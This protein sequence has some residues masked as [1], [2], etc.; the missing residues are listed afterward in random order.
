MMP[1]RTNPFALGR[2]HPFEVS[3]PP[4]KKEKCPACG[5]RT[6]G[7]LAEA[8]KALTEAA[9]IVAKCGVCGGPRW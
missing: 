5:R 6:D 1:E 9:K 4:P 2:H 8:V 3:P 7:K